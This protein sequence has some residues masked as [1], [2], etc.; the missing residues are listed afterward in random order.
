MAIKHLTEEGSMARK[1]VLSAPGEYG[2]TTWWCLHNTF[3]R[4]LTARQGA[5]MTEFA[6]TH[7][8]PGKNP[9]ETRTKLL[10]VDTAA[11]KWEEIMGENIPEQMLKSVYI[12]IMDGLTRSHLT[13]YQGKSTSAEELKNHIVR[14][15]TNA[16]LDSN[17]M[18]I[19]SV[20]VG[21][22]GGAS[23]PPEPADAHKVEEEWPWYEINAMGYYNNYW[24]PKGKGK[25]GK[26]KVFFLDPSNQ[27]HPV[28][29]ANLTPVAIKV[30]FF[31]NYDLL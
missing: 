13:P 23:S 3:T 17:A 7:S 12:G 26:E 25:D 6:A 8:K 27:F 10:E 29:G 11:K 28:I 1:I 24:R 31:S 18:Q 15:I 4:N 30:R 2:F 22:V 9:S 14:F 20:D 16:V 21:D 5:V 19:G